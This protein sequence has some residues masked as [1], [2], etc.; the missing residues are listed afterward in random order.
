MIFDQDSLALR[1]VH[2]ETG[3]CIIWCTSPCVSHTSAS[4]STS[5]HSSS[6]RSSS[7]FHLLSYRENRKKDI[8]LRIG[9]NQM[10][11]AP[12]QPSENETMQSS[13]NDKSTKLIILSKCVNH[14]LYLFFQDLHIQINIYSYCKLFIFAKIIKV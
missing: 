2:W 4:G 7:S 8:C 13:L 12:K 9:L 5:A 1:G 11:Y 14:S 6:L 3:F 10:M